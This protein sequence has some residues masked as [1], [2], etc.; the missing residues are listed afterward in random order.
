MFPQKAI[1]SKDKREQ[2]RQA[3]A[4]VAQQQQQQAM[5]LEAAKAAPGLAK[6]AEPNSPME[7]IGEA[8]G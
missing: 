8:I 1:N 7:A 4:Q 5:M 3:R 6:G 2:I